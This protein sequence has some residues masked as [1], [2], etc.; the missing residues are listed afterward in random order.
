HP[1]VV[2]VDESMLS[3]VDLPQIVA[4]WALE[5]LPIIAARTG[6][7]H[8]QATPDQDL[9]HGRYRGH[10]QALLGQM[11]PDLLGTP[12][13]QPFLMQPDDLVFD[14]NRGHPWAVYRSTRSRRQPFGPL[15][16]IPAQPLVHLR[17]GYPEHRRRLTGRQPSRLDLH[18]D[19]QSLIH[20]IHHL[21]RHASARY[22]RNQVSGMSP[23]R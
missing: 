1:E 20:N 19:T 8:E 10:G 6:S 18:H 3:A 13:A 21:Q 5:P 15:G 12:A 2:T 14:C 4:I 22:D 23:E 7:G 9:V 11:G 16:A 17:F